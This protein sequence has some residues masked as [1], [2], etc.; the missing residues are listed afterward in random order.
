MITDQQ[1]T[2]VG[3][4]VADIFADTRGTITY[5][6]ENNEA[7]VDWDEK[8]VGDEDEVFPLDALRVVQQIQIDAD[9]YEDPALHPIVE[10]S[11]TPEDGVTNYVVNTP[12][13]GQH[14]LRGIDQ[15]RLYLLGYHLTPNKR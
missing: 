2:K 9:W 1:P 12:T 8:P 10:V 6:N 14:T 11:Y 7:H 13:I 15:I 3:Q 4:R 5:L